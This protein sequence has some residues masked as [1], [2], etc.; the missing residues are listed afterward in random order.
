MNA[1]STYELNNGYQLPVIGFGSII[2]DGEPTVTAIKAA[3]KAGYRN[4]DTA[5]IH[6]N[7]RGV[8][9]AVREALAEDPTLHREDLFISTKAWWDHR[10]YE[11]TW[12]AFEESMDKLG[13][14]YVDQYLIHWPANATWHDDWKQLNAD[15]WRALEELYKAGRIKSIGV[16]NFLANHLEALIEMADIKPMVD[17]IEYHPGFAQKE[18]AEY[19]QAHD[20]VVEAWSPFGGPGSH[21]L[22]DATINA[23][24]VNHHKNAGQVVLRWLLQK[25]IVPLP[26][27]L[28][29]DPMATN[30]E[31]FDFELTADE[32]AAIETVPYAGGMGCNSTLTLHAHNKGEYSCKL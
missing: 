6:G 12:Q 10:G 19:A 14:D 29:P 1:Q 2:P 32:M 18:A 13:L 31:I 7:E 17:Q 15:T 30:L 20:I 27:A 28:N 8:G 26:K 4:I 9:Q 5:G 24:A 3:I 16:S 25:G 11:R 22:Q 21:V 23:I